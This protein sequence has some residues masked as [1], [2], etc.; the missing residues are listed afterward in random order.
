MGGRRRAHP[1][2]EQAAALA[3]PCGKLSKGE[4]GKPSTGGIRARIGARYHAGNRGVL[5]RPTDRT[6]DVQQAG[7]NPNDEIN[8]NDLIRMTTGNYPSSTPQPTN[9]S[10]RFR[11]QLGPTHGRTRDRTAQ[12]AAHARRAAQKARAFESQIAKQPVREIRNALAVSLHADYS[13]RILINLGTH[14]EHFATAQEMSTAYC[15]WE[16]HLV[17][18][19]Q[20]LAEHGYVQIH[21]GRSGGV[22]LAREPKEI[23][24]AM[25]CGTPSQTCGSSSASIVKQTGAL[26]RQGTLCGQCCARRWTQTLVC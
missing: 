25:W 26:L 23:G 1:V 15:I 2:Q 22:T 13:L 20:S 10:F 16:H 7:E 3:Q 12:R 4:Y 24:S 21:T 18:V 19:V 17:R 6:P 5:P 8:E 11:T 14:R 9:S